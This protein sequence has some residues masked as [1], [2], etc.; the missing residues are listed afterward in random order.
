VDLQ[1]E[2][3]ELINLTKNYLL[4]EN[5]TQNSNPQWIVSELEIYNYFKN[6]A[7]KNKHSGKP[8]QVKLPEALLKPKDR[9]PLQPPPVT[10]ALQYLGKP[11]NPKESHKPLELPVNSLSKTLNLPQREIETAKNSVFQLEPLKAATKADL[12]DVRKIV[13]ELFP[14]QLI[15]DEIAEKEP[16]IVII[17]D[18]NEKYIQAFLTNFARAIDILIAPASVMSSTRFLKTKLTGLKLVIQTADNEYVREGPHKLMHV[19]DVVQYLREPKLKAKL[20]E[21]TLQHFKA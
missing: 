4:Q 20:W 18:N 13:Q 12:N 19:L 17:S 7:L 3:R 2:Y 5:E 6:Y 11:V 14:R 9:A 21:N 10:D 8:P 15:L 16:Q 1:K